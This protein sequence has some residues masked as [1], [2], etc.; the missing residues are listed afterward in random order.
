MARRTAHYIRYT[1][2][3]ILAIGIT[4]GDVI[5]AQSIPP[6]IPDSLD[7]SFWFRALL[8]GLLG[9]LIWLAKNQDSRIKTLELAHAEFN[10]LKV[11]RGHRINV[12][13]R[14]HTEAKAR[15]ELLNSQL[16]LQREL[17][18]TQYARKEDME[19]FQRHID[20]RFDSML[21][22]LTNV[23]RPHNQRVGDSH[24]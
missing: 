9:I 20:T 16:S 1:A 19:A 3:M 10:Q 14:E 5:I 23:L 6:H 17:L 11:E 13:E 15:V 2:Y 8:S 22:Q 18:L 21:Q 24:G 12:L 4:W 7:I